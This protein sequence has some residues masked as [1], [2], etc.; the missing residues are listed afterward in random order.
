M[1]KDGSALK[2]LVHVSVQTLQAAKEIQKS[3]G[4]ALSMEFESQ[5]EIIV[6]AN[7]DVSE[8]SAAKNEE[9][10][11]T[12]IHEASVETVLKDMFEVLGG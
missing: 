2:K 5:K 9:A 7:V 4:E 3:S 10:V 8:L 1:V 12:T 6:V 11:V